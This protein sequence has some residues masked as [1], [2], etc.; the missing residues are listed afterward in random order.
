[1]PLHYQHLSSKIREEIKD[2]INSLYVTIM[3]SITL[4]YSIKTCSE[5]TGI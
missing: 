4:K 3:N 1:M 2:K 5:N